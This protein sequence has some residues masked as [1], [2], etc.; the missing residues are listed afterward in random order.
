MMTVMA[1]NPSS[2]NHSKMRLNWFSL[3]FTGATATLEEPFQRY[4]VTRNLPQLRI[5]LLMGTLMYGLFGVL[6]ALVLPQ[7][8]H[9]TWLIRY[10]FVCPVILAVLWATYIPRLYRH[11]QPLRSLIIAIGGLGIVLMIVVAPQPINHQYYA[12]LILIFIFGYSFIFL[13][14]LWAS[15]SGWMIVIFYEVAA[16][17]TEIPST[18]RIISNFFLISANFAGMLVCYAMEYSSRRNF[19]LLHLLRQEQRKIQEAN[20]QLEQRVAERTESLAKMN[21]QLTQEIAERRLAEQERQHLE[22]QLKQAEK[23][24]TIGK[25]A[26]GVA[27]DLN[28]ILTGLVGYP[29]ILLLDAPADS[30][31]RKSLLIIKQSGEK[32]SAI[33]QDMLTLSRQGIAEKKAVNINSVID[34]YLHSPEYLQMQ[35]NHPNVHLEVNIQKDLLNVKGSLF[36]ISKILMNL[37]NNAFE[38][39]LVSGSIKISTRNGY[40]DQPVNA[41]EKIPE[42][43]YAIL[44]VTDSGIGISA[45]DARHIFEPFFTKK[46]L[47]RS[48]TGLGMTLVWST[49]KD[50][51]GFIDVQSTEGRGV[52]LRNLFPGNQA[53]S[54]GYRVSLQVGRLPG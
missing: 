54:D 12:G 14:F 24:E 38:A 40:L 42:G 6:D 27:H 25:L 36:Q 41:Y 20:E 3:A 31:S 52:H 5:A 2:G 23:M 47:G 33:V 37:I 43:E 13:R 45:E 21:C 8:K 18:E 19:F 1:P 16:F 50:H 35:S 51:D 34:S 4:Y 7:H 46:K 32:A 30:R 53:G 48:G 9:F 44:N 39:N 11:L 29:D 17:L 26:A 49:L 28:N 22:V 10:A 15:L